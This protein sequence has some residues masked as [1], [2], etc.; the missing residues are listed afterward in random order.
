MTICARCSPPAC[1]KPPRRVAEAVQVLQLFRP[2]DAEPPDLA[3]LVALVAR[4]PGVAVE[5]RPGDAHRLARWRDAATGAS[6]LIQIG[7]PPLEE[8]T[9]HPPRAYQGWAPLALALHLPL[10][11]P[12]WFCVEALSMVE[13]LLA[14]D[15]SW[16][17]LDE[18]DLHATP[19][20]DA[21]PGPWSRPRVIASWERLREAQ[22]ETRSS[23]PRMRLS[24]SVAMWRYRRE[25]PQGIQRHPGHRW[26]PVSA[27]RATPLARR[28]APACGWSLSARSP[29]PPVELVVIPG[30]APLL[31]AYEDLVAAMHGPGS[32]AEAGIAG[33]ALANACPAAERLRGASRAMTGMAAL[34]DDSWRD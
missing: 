6:C 2:M 19:S 12:H 15:P 4:L 16:R 18:E 11:G 8:D 31:V 10:S 3:E 5:G 24:A 22:I 13:A 29:L 25:A 27:R 20:G 7:E 1:A 23:T 17:A 26:P 21:C 14:D 30:A 34:D 28:A 9:L 33:A 32:P